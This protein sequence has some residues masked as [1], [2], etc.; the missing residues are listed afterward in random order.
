[1]EQNKIGS[2]LEEGLPPGTLLA[3]RHGWISDTHADAGIVFTPAGDYVIVEFLYKPDWLEW[4]L[5]SPL[6]SDVSREQQL[7]LGDWEIPIS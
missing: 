7:R 3:H 2:L 1:M 4:E 6:L 5:S